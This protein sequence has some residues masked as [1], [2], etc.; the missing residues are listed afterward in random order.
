MLKKIISSIL[1]VFLLVALLPMNADA[2]GKIKVQVNGSLLTFDVQPYAD[3]ERVLVPL[4]GV[5]EKLGGAV[6]WDNSTQSVTV[7]HKGGTVKL[8]LNA[9]TVQIN[10]V[11]KGIDVPAKAK[12]GRTFVP[13]RFVGEA[14]G[15]VVNWSDKDQTVYI[16]SGELTNL[17]KPFSKGMTKTDIEKH[18]SNSKYL[19]L[20]DGTGV[21]NAP[22]TIYG[23]PADAQFYIAENGLMT[24]MVTFEVTGEVEAVGKFYSEQI[25]KEYGA[26]KANTLPFHDYSNVWEQYMSPLNT[27]YALNVNERLNGRVE[28]K[29]EKVFPDTKTT[30]TVN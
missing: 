21:M 29:I 5:F 19:D 10:G 18:I 14:M 13:L 23:Y 30:V 28:V 8:K 6:S 26:Y 17:L 1:A 25:K 4:R 16:F 12:E 22:V 7:T 11:E 3:N 9:K 2:A 24:I 20:S 15:A 27:R